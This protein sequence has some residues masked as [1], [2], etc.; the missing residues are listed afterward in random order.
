MTSSINT[1]MGTHEWLM[2][3]VLSVLWGAW[4]QRCNMSP[5]CFYD[6]K[7]KGSHSDDDSKTAKEIIENRVDYKFARHLLHY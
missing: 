4:S 1:S 3:V 5:H 7:S 6:T 2:L